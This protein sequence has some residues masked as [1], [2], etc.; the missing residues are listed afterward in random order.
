MVYFALVQS[1]YILMYGILVWGSAYNN[2]LESLNVT[3]RTLIGVKMK[4]FNDLKLTQ[5]IYSKN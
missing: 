4:H 5:M 3:H 1:T 2:V